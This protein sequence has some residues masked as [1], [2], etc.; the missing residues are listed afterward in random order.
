MF[1]DNSILIRAILCTTFDAKSEF[2]T[3][4][5]VFC[6]LSVFRELYQIFFQTLTI[7][8]RN[9]LYLALKLRNAIRKICSTSAKL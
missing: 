5:R 9:N 6:D 7:S 1:S 4:N 2:Q 3:R 8:L